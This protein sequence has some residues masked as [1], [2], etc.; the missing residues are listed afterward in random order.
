M[1]IVMSTTKIHSSSSYNT[2]NMLLG[3]V[4]VKVLLI[5][6]FVTI[7]YLI[8]HENSNYSTKKGVATCKN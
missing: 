3:K 8:L 6:I 4:T 1:F 7:V 2:V 5:S